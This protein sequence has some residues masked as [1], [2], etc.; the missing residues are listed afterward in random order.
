M[1]FEKRQNW[2]SRNQGKIAVAIAV[3]SIGAWGCQNTQVP[4]GPAGEDNV[5][6]GRNGATGTVTQ[7]AKPGTT[8]PAQPGGAVTPGQAG[9]GTDTTGGTVTPGQTGGTDATGGQTGAPADPLTTTPSVIAKTL[10]QPTQPMNPA[11]VNANPIKWNHKAVQVDPEVLAATPKGQKATVTGRVVDEKGKP[12]VGVPVMTDLQVTTTNAEGFYTIEIDAVPA[13]PIRFGGNAAG[14]VPF[15]DFISPFAEETLRYDTQVLN[16]DSNVT[17]IDVTKGGTA[18]S[19]ALD[20]VLS[21]LSV[22]RPSATN[23]RETFGLL[24]AP[25]MGTSGLKAVYL[26]IPPGGL[27]LPD[28][29]TEA[30]VRLTWLNPLPRGPEKPYGD[31][32]G[33]LQTYTAW[34]SS[35]RTGAKVDQQVAFNPVN[36]A[37]LDIGDAKIAPGAELRVKWVVGPD[38]LAKYPIQMSNGQ[39]FMPCYQ[40][41]TGEGWTK[42]VLA[43]VFTEDGHT[44]TQYT[45]RGSN[46][47]TV[48]PE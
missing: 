12:A 2:L 13:S 18:T 40:Y 28:G 46:S 22:N 23:P 8:N 41:D 35:A 17:K 3:A 26:E 34:D 6:L 15:D 7:P 1:S 10:I 5:N 31:L 21:D 11:T 29:Q 36:F 42:P 37:D 48:V 47:P 45:M 14:F 27:I 24:Q 25:D 44:W 4:T 43:T 32:Y 20:T 39:A 19:G 30:T 33:P 9:G 16:L 38:V